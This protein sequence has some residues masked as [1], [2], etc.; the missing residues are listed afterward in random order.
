MSDVFEVVLVCFLYPN[1]YLNSLTVVGFA[2]L[3]GFW[4]TDGLRERHR[5]RERTFFRL[6]IWMLLVQKRCDV[7]R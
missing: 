1:S 3:S 5:E 4:L 6:Q 2:L 7:S